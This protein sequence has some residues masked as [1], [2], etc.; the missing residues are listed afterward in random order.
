MQKFNRS[1][2]NAKQ[3]DP[4]VRLNDSSLTGADYVAV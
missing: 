2:R 4:K 1:G 3:A